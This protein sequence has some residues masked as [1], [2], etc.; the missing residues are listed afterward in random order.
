[1]IAVLDWHSSNKFGLPNVIVITRQYNEE[2]TGEAGPV[3]T[4][5]LRG[6]RR[7]LINLF[8]VAPVGECEIAHE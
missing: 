8:A 1:M 6:C 5:S 2:V 4:W 7:A 3:S